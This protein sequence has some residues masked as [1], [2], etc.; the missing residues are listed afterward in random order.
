MQPNLM[1]WWLVFPRLILMLFGH[2]DFNKDGWD[3]F[4]FQLI[5]GSF[6]MAYQVPS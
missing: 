6:T 2:G 4:G 1:L 3:D 5:D